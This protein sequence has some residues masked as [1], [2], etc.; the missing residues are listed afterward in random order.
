MSK[1]QGISRATLIIPASC[2]VSISNCLSL[3]PS[4]AFPVGGPTRRRLGRKTIG[5]PL[6]FV[7][8][9][10][11]KTGAAIAPN[12]QAMEMPPNISIIPINV[13]P[14]TRLVEGREVTYRSPSNRAL[15]RRCFGR[16]TQF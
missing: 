2:C 6:F 7:R 13:P 11:R 16:N 3:S 12:V 10:N 4:I 5:S 15:I 8:P 14:M 9:K 1:D